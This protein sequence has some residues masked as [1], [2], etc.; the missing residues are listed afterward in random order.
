MRS[1]TD[2]KFDTSEFTKKSL[3][4]LIQKLIL[5]TRESHRRRT[6]DTQSNIILVHPKSPIHTN[7]FT[8]EVAISHD[9]IRQRSI[10]L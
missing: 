1:L 6:H 2:L 5:K 7:S 4:I 3:K 9:M 10:L 8:V